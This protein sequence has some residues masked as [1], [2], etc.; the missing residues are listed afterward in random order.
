[1]KIVQR[2]FIVNLAWT[3]A[4]A[5]A[6]LVGIFAFLS[7][8]DQLEDAGQGNY[9]AYQAITYVILTLP[10]LAY[11]IIP[12]AAMIGGMTCIALLSRNSELDAVR[13]AGVSEYSLAGFV[14]KAALVIVLFSLLVGELVVPASEIKA[15]FQRSIAL[16]EQVAMQ[17]KY[18]FWARDGN[19]FINIRK[20]LPG[21]VI[22]EIYIYEFDDQDRLRSSITADNARYLEDRW[23][24]EGV[25]RTI[26]DGSG[27]SREQFS[28][29]TW[30]SRVDDGLINLVI[31]NPLYMSLRNLSD[32]IRM[33]K[34]NSQSAAAYEQ[35]FYGKLVRPFTILAM[36][37][38]SVPLVAARKRSDGLGRHVF[39]GALIGVIFYF[40]NSAS[41]HIGIVYGVHPL[42]SSAVPTLLLY[43]LLLRLYYR[44]QPVLFPTAGREKSDVPYRPGPRETRPPMQTTIR[45][46]EK[47]LWSGFSSRAARRLGLSGIYA[48]RAFQGFAVLF[49]IARRNRTRR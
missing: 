25:D 42:I 29:A 6:V 10:R 45:R 31:I 20:I 49:S 14:A 22:E 37:I 17:T 43:L 35:A 16:T 28:Q 32:S 13:L 2:Y 12:V 8:I 5:L 15:R 27:I 18:G 41:G 33:L 11:E 40:V 44:Q 39:T 23:V 34:S 36:I 46:Q 4:L 9:D 19:S 48:R 24:L 30:E 47:T 7:L 26:I 21:N 1:M 3:T 38:L